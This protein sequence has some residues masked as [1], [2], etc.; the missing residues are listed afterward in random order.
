MMA[1]RSKEPSR[2]TSGATVRA[3]RLALSVEATTAAFVVMKVRRASAVR[4]GSALRLM[5]EAGM[6]LA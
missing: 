3:K 2:W 6:R 5:C 1:E 4:R